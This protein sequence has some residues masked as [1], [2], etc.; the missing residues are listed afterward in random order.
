MTHRSVLPLCRL[1]YQVVCREPSH[2]R[3]HH[4]HH[5][6]LL[7]TRDTCRHQSQR[8]PG[9][10]KLAATMNMILIATRLPAFLPLAGLHQLQ[11][12]HRNCLRCRLPF[13]PTLQHRKFMTRKKR[14]RRSLKTKTNFMLLPHEP[15]Q[16]APHHHY[17]PTYL[18]T[19]A[20]LHHYHLP[21]RQELLRPSVHSNQERHHV[22]QPILAGDGQWTNPVLQLTLA[23]SHAI[24][25]STTVADG[26][27]N[28]TRR[29]PSS[30]TDQT[31]A[32]KLKSPQ[33]P[34]VAG[35]LPS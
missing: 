21:F 25:L 4:N 26:G 19:N 1:Q 35:R 27:H 15:L 17:L 28:P 3:L 11:G 6:N 16:I 33:P 10:R 34:N 8:K 14:T 24:Y 5:G 12:K 32:L 29:H 9:S 2:P 23:S 31:F 13:L 18:R 30:K 7:R 20:L 22:N